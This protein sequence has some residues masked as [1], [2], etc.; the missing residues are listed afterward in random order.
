MD[1][2]EDKHAEKTSIRSIIDFIA[3]LSLLGIWS[4]GMYSLSMAK[5][6]ADERR[7][8]TAQH[9]KEWARQIR[10][11]EIE[12]VNGSVQFK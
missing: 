11:N 7:E 2:Q 10:E 8:A 6:I 4:Y 3:F 5:V 9:T 12:I 1:A